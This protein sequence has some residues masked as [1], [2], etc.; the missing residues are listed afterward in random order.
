MFT[1]VTIKNLKDYLNNP[2]GNLYYTEAPADSNRYMLVDGFSK[3]DCIAFLFNGGK[4]VYR[5][6]AAVAF[7][8]FVA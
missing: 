2:Y 5:E 6:G 3:G 1:E 8:N 7:V 4:L